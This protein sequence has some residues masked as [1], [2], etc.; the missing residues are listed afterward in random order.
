MM[1]TPSQD[2]VARHRNT[3]HR[4][5]LIAGMLLSL[6]IG[7]YFLYPHI[8]GQETASTNSI[9]S[10]LRVSS[11]TQK[12]APKLESPHEQRVEPDA[13]LTSD[14]PSVPQLRPLRPEKLLTARQRLRAEVL[15]DHPT[16]QHF[17]DLK[18]R[19]LPDQQTRAE[20]EALLMDES[21]LLAASRALSEVPSD[22]DQRDQIERMEEVSLLGEALRWEDNPSRGLAMDA[23]VSAI[24]ANNLSATQPLELQRSLAGDK[25]ELY[26]M[27]LVTDP[28][29]AADVMKSAEG[30]P[31]YPVLEYA[32][33]RYL[34][35]MQQ[36]G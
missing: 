34:N 19:V 17:R 27:L 22:F 8:Q 2:F 35:W 9:E 30:T 32:Q 13:A 18:R 14:T 33:L 6:S 36:E 24:Q 20:Y 1:N 26:Y 7:G 16:L 21:V 10:G 28:A 3:T 11:Q 31:I 5:G 25:W 29:L 15:A 23:V 12:S 4:S